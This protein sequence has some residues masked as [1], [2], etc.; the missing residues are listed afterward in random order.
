MIF[1]SILSMI[2]SRADK[3]IVSKLLPIGVLGYYGFASNAVS[4]AALITGAISQAAFPS[5]AALFK[6]GDRKRL[7]AQYAE[8]QD[9]ICYITVPLFAAFP[10]A[11]LP[12]FTYLFNLEIAKTLLLPVSLLSLGFYMNGTL[13]LPYQF[14]LAA[15][16]P[17]IS[18]R[19]NLYAV[20]IILPITVLLIYKLK[21]L[22]AGLSSV[23]L[24]LFIYAYAIRR[25][26]RECIGFPARMWYLHVL[27]FYALAGLIYG[28]AWIIL[29]FLCAH[30]FF[31]KAIAY[32]GATIIFLSSAYFI[33]GDE[34]RKTIDNKLFRFLTLNR[35]NYKMN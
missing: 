5:L 16:K 6:T 3:I 21:L 30:S 32:S 27:K 25:I 15:G 29:E 2:G 23:L 1:I 33:I 31:S 11:A 20:L 26:C 12:L 35:V 14:S 8:L 34:L 13:N 10:F 18:V 28:S 19:S 24:H 17:E 9:L 22:G 4:K 7:I